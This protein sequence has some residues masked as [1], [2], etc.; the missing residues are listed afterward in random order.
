MPSPHETYCR[1]GVDPAFKKGT[2]PKISRSTHTHS[3]HVVLKVDGLT[4]FIR[5][6]PLGESLTSVVGQA[7][8]AACLTLR[9]DD[10]HFRGFHGSQYP[11]ELPTSVAHGGTPLTHHCPAWHRL[12]PG[13]SP[14][15]ATDSKYNSRRFTGQEARSFSRG[16]SQK[17]S[18]KSSLQTLDDSLSPTTRQNQSRS[19]PR[20]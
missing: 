20:T 18:N 6:P 10:F 1:K 13:V 2:Q 4:E 12:T 9:T 19:S 15:M 3:H 14:N 5:R 8:S 16:Y 11:K 17:A 7:G